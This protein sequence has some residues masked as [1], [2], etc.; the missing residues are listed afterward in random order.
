MFGQF[1]NEKI[2]QFTDDSFFV[3]S[4]KSVRQLSLSQILYNFL[5]CRYIL[6]ASVLFT[7][8]VLIILLTKLIV[9]QMLLDFKHY[10]NDLNTCVH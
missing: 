9:S 8:T 3:S 1:I 2:A 6:I 5:T 10:L 4:I 7:I